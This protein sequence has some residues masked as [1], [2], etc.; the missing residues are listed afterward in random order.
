[1]I[2]LEQ[3]DLEK[4]T[5]RNYI[6]I[7]KTVMVDI[8]KLEP[9]PFNRPL[10]KNQEKILQLKK[11]IQQHGFYGSQPLVIRSIGDKYQIIHGEHR[12][13][14]AKELDFKELPCII[15]EMDDEETLIQLIIGNIQ[16]ENKPL[17]IGLNALEVTKKGSKAGYSISEYAKKIG[18]NRRTV[19]EYVQSAEVYKFVMD[20][21]APGCQLL[22]EV[23]K[24]LEISR[25]SQ[26]D[27]LWLHDMIIEKDLSKTQV[28]LVC[29]KAK[30]IDNIT[31][32]QELIDLFKVEQTKKKATSEALEGRNRAISNM[33]PA[34]EAANEFYQNLESEA[35][36]YSYDIYKNEIVKESVDIHE[37]FL[38]ELKNQST[39]SKSTVNQA[40]DEVLQKKQQNSKEAAEQ[41]ANY[42]RKEKHNKEL[43]ER[44]RIEKERG[45]EVF[46]LWLSGL[47]IKDIADNLSISSAAVEEY[48]ENEKQEKLDEGLVTFSDAG[49]KDGF[50]IPIYNIW[51]Q[52]NKSDTPDYFGNSEIR[53]VENLLYLY[54]KTFDMV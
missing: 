13:S 52:Q 47:P 8:N 44:R 12:Y 28:E 31:D 22:E 26:S 45:K 38:Q 19:S 5:S 6:K 7:Q 20:K 36:F 43:Q 17:E 29:K 48:L 35:V 51:K 30:E 50:K 2:I 11:S 37:L 42:Y 33:K 24:L 54:T 46:K 18:L 32:I 39:L 14:A 23:K 41:V 21:L 15:E 49:K 16:T 3:K 1:M 34:L 9:H 10:G 53:W 25:C 27:W 40:I 4:D